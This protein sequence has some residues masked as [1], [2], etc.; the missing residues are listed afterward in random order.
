MNIVLTF[1]GGFKENFSLLSG[2]G[3]GV[4]PIF[5]VYPEV[6][7]YMNAQCPGC[8]KAG[9]ALL[10]LSCNGSF[11]QSMTS[12]SYT[13]SNS[14]GKESD[15]FYLWELRSICCTTPLSVIGS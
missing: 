15:D 6:C 3:G 5:L 14:L 1:Q 7:F 8:V 10:L 9:L 13:G 2:S 4:D 11:S 12:L